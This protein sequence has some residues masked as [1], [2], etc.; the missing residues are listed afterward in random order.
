MVL[1]SKEFLQFFNAF[2]E[3]KNL[4]FIDFL[5]RM[6]KLNVKEIKIMALEI[7]SELNYDMSTFVK[8]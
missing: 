7:L 3:Q 8:Q 5:Y 6:F 1:K 4:R 2:C